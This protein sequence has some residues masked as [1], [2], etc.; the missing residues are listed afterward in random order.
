MIY[1]SARDAPAMHDL[2]SF[3]RDREKTRHD[4][5]HV[6]SREQLLQLHVMS[7]TLSRFTAS[8]WIAVQ[9]RPL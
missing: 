1:S 6:S 3:A 2:R 4:C 5:C 7:A 8:L 9:E